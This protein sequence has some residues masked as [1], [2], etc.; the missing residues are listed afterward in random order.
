MPSPF[1]DILS[2]SI[3]YS[4]SS[5]LHRLAR[6]LARTHHLHL[7]TLLPYS[8]TLRLANPHLIHITALLS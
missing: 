7:L 2:E 8:I 1:I 4:P 6:L 5:P 3:T